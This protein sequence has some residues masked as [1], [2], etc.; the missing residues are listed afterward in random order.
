METILQ[1]DP[2]NADFTDAETLKVLLSLMPDN[3]RVNFEYAK[4][5][6]NRGLNFQKAIR[7]EPKNAEFIF[8]FAEHLERTQ[9]KTRAKPL[10][11]EALDLEPENETYILA[12]VRLLGEYNKR[13]EKQALLNAVL[14]KNPNLAEANFLLGETMR[15]WENSDFEKKT[16]YFEKALRY[17]KDFDKKNLAKIHAHLG[18]ACERKDKLDIAADHYKRAHAL[19]YNSCDN[20]FISFLAR[21]RKGKL[22]DVVQDLKSSFTISE[23][24]FVTSFFDKYAVLTPGFRKSLKKKNP[25]AIVQMKRYRAREKSWF[26]IGLFPFREETFPK[27][28]TDVILD[29]LYFVE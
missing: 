17:A 22:A 29:F 14:K 27:V 13:D 16:E 5:F 7:M 23:T 11:K 6:G 2:L 25:G 15:Y 8:G 12:Y 20:N 19:D 1:T 4:I 21:H 3:P 26:V 24:N 10:F 9:S 18:L 28:V